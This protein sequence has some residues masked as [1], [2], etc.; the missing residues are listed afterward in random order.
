MQTEQYKTGYYVRQPTHIAEQTRFI[1]AQAVKKEYAA[2]WGCDVSFYSSSNVVVIS[3]CHS[4]SL[5]AW[6]GSY[7]CW[8]ERQD[9]SFEVTRLYRINF[10]TYIHRV[11][12]WKNKIKQEKIKKI[13]RNGRQNH[14]RMHHKLY[15]MIVLIWNFM[16]FSLNMLLCY[17]SKFERSSVYAY[18][19]IW[20]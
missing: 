8:V 6:L 15:I 2:D 16:T 17:L 11:P 3:Q 13:V 5:K 4:L 7:R 1:D 20:F 14:D 9:F 12:W 19:Y 18:L 10:E